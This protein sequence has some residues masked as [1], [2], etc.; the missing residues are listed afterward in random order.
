MTRRKARRIRVKRNR[1]A[2]RYALEACWGLDETLQFFR[3]YH[4]ARSLRMEWRAWDERFSRS[5]S[6]P[7]ATPRSQ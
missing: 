2:R 6:P 3:K 1:T 5:E 7:R 4:T